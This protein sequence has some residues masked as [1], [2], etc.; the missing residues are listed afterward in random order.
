MANPNPSPTTR[1]KLGQSGNP[2]GT[3]G[4]QRATIL[5]ALPAVRSLDEV[6]AD[7]RS[8]KGTARE[9]FE[10]VARDANNPLDLRLHCAAV[11]LRHEE[12]GTG[13]TQPILIVT[14]VPRAADDAGDGAVLPSSTATPTSPEAVP[15]VR[16]RPPGTSWQH[17]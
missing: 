12:G 4:P 13:Q 14:G 16:T 6:L 11:L 9:L 10:S 1:F 3:S 15:P 5:R 17:H 2:R 8:W 7:E